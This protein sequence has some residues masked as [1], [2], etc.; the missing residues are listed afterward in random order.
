MG[1]AVVNENGLLADALRFLNNIIGEM[2]IDECFNGLGKSCFK[3]SLPSEGI[4]CL[5]LW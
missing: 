3:F 5:L 2:E 4:G 1:D